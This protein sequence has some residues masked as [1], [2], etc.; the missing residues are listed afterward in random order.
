MS[1]SA[2]ADLDGA[3]VGGRGRTRTY[4]GIASVFT[5]PP[6]CR[7]GHSPP[8][9]PHRIDL[10]RKTASFAGRDSRVL[11]A[12]TPGK[13]MEAVLPVPDQVRHSNDVT[14]THR[15]APFWRQT[16]RDPPADRAARAL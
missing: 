2:M 12:G 15:P 6:L 1:K 16:G 4:E 13:S 5:V 3:K 14:T 11:W 9:P 7:P 8:K 10:E